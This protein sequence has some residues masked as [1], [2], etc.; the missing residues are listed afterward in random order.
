MFNN[1][2]TTLKRQLPNDKKRKAK[3]A[4]EYNKLAREVKKE[5]D[6]PTRKQKTKKAKK[7]KKKH[8]SLGEEVKQ[9]ERELEAAKVNFADIDWFKNITNKE[10]LIAK[11]KTCDFW[12]DVWAITTLEIGLNTKFIILSSDEY[13]HGNYDAVLRCGDL[14][15][16]SVEEKPILNQIALWLNTLEIIIN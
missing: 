9:K 1:E 11:M 13:R 12:A 7:M 15:P 10:Q 6:V 5:K 14:V 16:N 8:K 3:L 2:L 4:K